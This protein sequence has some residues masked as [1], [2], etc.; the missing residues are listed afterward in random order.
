M[1]RPYWPGAVLDIVRVIVC[2]SGTIY[3]ARTGLISGEAALAALAAVGA[4]AAIA[5]ALRPK[6]TPKGVEKPD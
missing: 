5:G 2:A 1:G 3:L 6:A 4:G